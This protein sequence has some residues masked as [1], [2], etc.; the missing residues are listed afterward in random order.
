MNTFQKIAVFL[1]V[2]L[3]TLRII[4][5]YI[6]NK[7][8]P[9]VERFIHESALDGFMIAATLGL[10]VSIYTTTLTIQSGFGAFTKIVEN[11]PEYSVMQALANARLAIESISEP[12]AKEIFTNVFDTETDEFKTTLTSIQNHG[13]EIQKEKAMLFGESVFNSAKKSV[14]TTS[15]V[16]PT[17]WWLTTEGN[18]Y[19]LKNEAALRRN[20][21]ISRI[22]I[23]SS[24]SELKELKPILQKQRSAGVTVYTIL[25]SKLPGRMSRD[26]IIVDDRLV[27]ELILDKDTRDFSKVIVNVDP[28]EVGRVQDA[29]NDLLR[30]AKTE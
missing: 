22:F 15:Y 10:A 13:M 8:K 20:V 7:D 1:T 29:W 5:R 12:S 16:S 23:F 24:E 21:H 2:F 3:I 4:F 9:P 14:L 19:F 11:A 28:K 26:I 27:G 6:H 30:F 25:A 18:A 17:S